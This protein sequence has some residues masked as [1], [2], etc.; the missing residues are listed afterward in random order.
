MTKDEELAVLREAAAKLGPYSYIGP[1]L[2]EQLPFIERDVQNDIPP[3]PTVAGSRAEAEQ[4]VKDAERD[5]FRIFETAASKAGKVIADA[6]KR[7]D[8]I[9]ERLKT[10]LHKC[11]A[12]L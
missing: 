1:W 9:R 6:E 5:A 7:A 8:S 2:L 4:I 11:L 3:T 10:E 12:T